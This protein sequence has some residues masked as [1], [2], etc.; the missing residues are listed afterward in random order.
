MNQQA[1]AYLQELGTHLTRLEPEERADIL[2]EVES[3]IFES[4]SNGTS[5]EEVLKA[6]GTPK[7]LANSYIGENLLKKGSFNLS[8]LFQ[9][10]KFYFVTG[11]S[12]MIIVPFLAVLSVALYLC[13]FLVVIVGIVSVVFMVLGT[14]L[15]FS[16]M[17][18]GF[19]QAPDFLALPI[20]L[21]F[22]LAFYLLSKK[23]WRW[24]NTYLL[25]VATAHRKLKS[26]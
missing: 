26:Q 13:T 5:T 7:A 6:L 12:G 14:P 3:H 4:L 23:L 8:N 20:C 17:N 21:V 10:I 15:P 18:L 24:L 11:F 9:L 2:E 22:G 19:W 1:A 16:V 25:S